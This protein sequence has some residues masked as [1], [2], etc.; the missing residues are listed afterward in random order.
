[1]TDTAQWF[2]TEHRPSVRDSC[3]ELLGLGN[4]TDCSPDLH[5][6]LTADCAL[7][8]QPPE[9]CH[10]TAGLCS[11]FQGRAAAVLQA[12]GLLSGL[13]Q[14]LADL[15]LLESPNPPSPQHTGRGGNVVRSPVV[16]AGRVGR[17]LWLSL[18]QDYIMTR[19]VVQISITSSESR[20]LHPLNH[21]PNQM[22]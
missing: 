13:H 19:Q 10:S 5:Q 17:F 3:V 20:F 7:E 9:C 1:M 21:H 15:Q 18:T 2:Q 11:L 22:P 6:R 8:T 4:P 14:R 12:Y 16:A